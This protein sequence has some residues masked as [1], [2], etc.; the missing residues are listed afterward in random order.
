MTLFG[1]WMNMCDEVAPAKFIFS[2]SQSSEG[3][4]P[5]TLVKNTIFLSITSSYP[6]M[7]ES[8]P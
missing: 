4:A 6:K 2:S 5:K 3:Q 1:H 8:K 7:V